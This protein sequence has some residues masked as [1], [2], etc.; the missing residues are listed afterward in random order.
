[1]LN[2]ITVHYYN[3]AN[4]RQIFYDKKNSGFFFF[5]WFPLPSDLT[6][7]QHLKASFFFLIS[8]MFY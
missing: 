7:G 2:K 1:M 3:G 6:A 8:D 5:F 4:Q